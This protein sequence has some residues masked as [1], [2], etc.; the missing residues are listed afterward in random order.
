VLP[1]WC[2]C[3]PWSCLTCVRGPGPPRHG[4]G[5]GGRFRARIAHTSACL[6]CGIAPSHLRPEA[7]ANDPQRQ[8]GTSLARAVCRRRNR[9]HSRIRP[10][11]R[12][13][14]G[15]S[16]VGSQPPCDS[17][18]IEDTWQDCAEFLTASH[19]G[20]DCEPV[21]C[22]GEE[23]ASRVRAGDSGSRAN[24]FDSYGH[25]SVPWGG[26]HLR[27]HEHRPAGVR[28]PSQSAFYPSTGRMSFPWPGAV[29][30]DTS[31]RSRQEAVK[32]SPRSP[33]GELPAATN[34]HLH[35][36]CL[37]IRPRRC[38]GNERW[39]FIVLRNCVS[40]N[41]RFYWKTRGFVLTQT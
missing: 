13:R 9:A 4:L 27:R 25:K 5:H 8:S 6:G 22:R 34:S 35:A 10:F 36:L 1:C 11:T 15:D 16:N 41:H 37:H 26:G 38:D 18:D 7:G 40:V 12:R 31:G 14:Q 23:W 30:P 39:V 17:S 3:A 20:N 24:L 19:A 33:D 21:R 29:V 32:K 28:P 2:S